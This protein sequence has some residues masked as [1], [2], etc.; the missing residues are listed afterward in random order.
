[1]PASLAPAESGDGDRVEAVPLET[2]LP[3]GDDAAQASAFDR[4]KSILFGDERGTAAALDARMAKIEA[5]QRELPARLPG[6]IERAQQA[7]IA[8][9]LA[10]PVTEALGS[11]VEQNR[12]L[13]ADVLFPVIGPAIRKAI[14]EA[15]RNLVADLNGAIESSLTPRGIRWRIEA[16]RSGVP[17][18]EIVLKHTLNYGIDHVFLIERDSGLVLDRE[19]APHLQSLDAD[20]IAG[21]LTAIGEFV[22]DSVGRDGGG[23][24]DAARVGEHLLWVVQ[25]PR[26]NLACFIHGVPPATLH[27][28]LEERLEAIHATLADDGVVADEPTRQSLQP[29]VLM[30]DARADAAP[31]AKSRWPLYL[32]VLVVVA[33]AAWLVAQRLR[34]TAWIEKVRTSLAAHPGFVLTR[35]ERAGGALTAHG[36][37]D[38]D[39]EPLDAAAIAGTGARMPLKFDTLG[40]VSTDDAIVE[41]RAR[42]LLDAPASVTID[43]RG[44]ALALGGHAD[45]TWILYAEDKAA[46]VPGVGS[47][48]FN[49]ASDTDAAAVRARQEIER[50]VGDINF[51]RVAFVRDTELADGAAAALD[52]LASDMARVEALAHEALAAV[53]WTTIGS[54]DDPGTDAINARLRA[55]RARWLAD[56]LVARGLTNVRADESAGAATENGRAAFVKPDVTWAKP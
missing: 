4:L 40:Y 45:G 31:V 28:V 1:M 19:S 29:D 51:R 24:L 36:L 14:A 15:L 42:R 7:Q 20:A 9:S 34:D 48:A 8:K 52:A 11:A 25:G 56:A 26:A 23:T 6:A 38:P 35:I 18:A 13:I 32:I 47:V 5:A 21:M 55:E 43:T 37:L 2:V 54:N 12:Q 50:L 30:R 49:V 27:A 22:R 33:L 46:W 10:R 3:A 41:R 53:A 44:G 16:W 17:Y 39:A